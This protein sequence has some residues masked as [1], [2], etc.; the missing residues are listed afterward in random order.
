MMAQDIINIRSLLQDRT[1]MKQTRTA[2]LHWTKALG[3]HPASDSDLWD[4]L[5]GMLSYF[6]CTSRNQLMMP[7]PACN[8]CTQHPSSFSAGFFSLCKVMFSRT[9]P[10]H[11]RM[12]SMGAGNR[13]E[14]AR[15]ERDTWL[16]KQKGKQNSSRVCSVVRTTVRPTKRLQ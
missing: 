7:R 2:V 9:P 14:D 5:W 8:L 16:T 10:F 11:S 13:Q 4:M 1:S 12:K 3:Q 15:E 6:S